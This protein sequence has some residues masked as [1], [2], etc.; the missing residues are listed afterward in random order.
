MRV[1]GPVSR[2]PDENHD[3]DVVGGV[4]AEEA[5]FMSSVGGGGGGIDHGVNKPKVYLFPINIHAH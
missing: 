1:A 4:V 5:S 2:S 3:P